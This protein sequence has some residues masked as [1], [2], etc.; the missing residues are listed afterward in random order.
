LAIIFHLNSS[1]IQ[2]KEKQRVKTWLLDII[3][4]NGFSTGE[5]NLV[6]AGD[7]ELLDLNQRFREGDYLTDVIAFDYSEKRKISGDIFIS[8][9]RVTENAL[10][11]SVD[12][13]EE[14]RRVF[15]HGIIHLM[16][17]KDGTEKEK[18]IMREMEDTCLKL[19]ADP[20]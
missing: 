16:G 17:Y 9:E 19:F 18:K 12:L 5:I 11:Y 3:D 2:V 6:I 13:Q 4:S 14:L 1:L 15:L 20:S 7:K 10:H 8:S